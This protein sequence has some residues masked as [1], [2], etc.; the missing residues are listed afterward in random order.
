MICPDCGTEMEVSDTTYSNTGKVFLGVIS[1]HTGDI[2][3]CPNEDCGNRWLANFI[4]NCLERWN[5]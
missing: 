1:Q 4:T 5:G 2:Y 3:T